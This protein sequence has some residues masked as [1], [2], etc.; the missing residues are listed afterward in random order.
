MMMVKDDTMESLKILDVVDAP[1]Q[2]VQESELWYQDDPE[3]YI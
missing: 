3:F 2:D 1:R